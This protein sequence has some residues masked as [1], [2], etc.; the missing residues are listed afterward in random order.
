M[1]KV[2]IT[3]SLASGKSLALDIIEKMG[4][5]VINC[6]HLVHSIMNQVDTLDLIKAKFPDCIS[7]NEVIR[8]KLG[9]VVFLN[10]DKLTVLEN[11]LY[12]KLRIEISRLCDLAISRGEKIIFVEI[13]LLFEKKQNHLY[14][15]I[16]CVDADRSTRRHRF[17]LRGGDLDMFAVIDDQHIKPEEKKRMSSF[18]VTNNNH[19]EDLELN[20]QN[21]IRLI[22]HTPPTQ[23]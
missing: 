20:L 19:K 23:L 2:A 1:I 4:Y 7:G 10:R 14:D 21:I 11:I 8:S 16:I 3:G 12:P 13:P 18:V 9:K 6:D 15:Y 22:L 17:G 5:S